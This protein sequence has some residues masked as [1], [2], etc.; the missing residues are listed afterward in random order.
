M[1]IEVTSCHR[2]TTVIITLKTYDR[3]DML[4]DDDHYNDPTPTTPTLWI[5]RGENRFVQQVVSEMTLMTRTNLGTYEFLW[6]TTGLRPGI[7]NI[8]IDCE[9]DSIKTHLEKPFTLTN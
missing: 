2:G 3:D 5:Q 8:E 9:V 7:Y 4:T 6:E 1:P